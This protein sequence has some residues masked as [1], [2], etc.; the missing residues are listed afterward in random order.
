M[1]IRICRVTIVFMPTCYLLEGV[2]I[3]EPPGYV[4]FKEKEKL[5]PDIYKS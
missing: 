3:M 1:S 4:E 5:L 2:E